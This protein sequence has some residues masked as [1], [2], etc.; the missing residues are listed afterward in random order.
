MD[1]KIIGENIKTYRKAKNLTQGD[2]ANL[3]RNQKVLYV[4]MRKDL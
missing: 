1:Y 4:S 2:L 3:I